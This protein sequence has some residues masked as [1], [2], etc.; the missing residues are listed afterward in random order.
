MVYFEM[1]AHAELKELKRE[2]K[3]R[4]DLI[5]VLTADRDNA[6]ATLKQHGLKIDHNVKVAIFYCILFCILFFHSITTLSFSI[7]SLRSF[8][9]ERLQLRLRNFPLM[10]CVARCERLH[11]N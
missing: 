8:P 11:R 3:Q 10:F 7:L 5:N 1:Q 9:T 4:E 6:I 2:M